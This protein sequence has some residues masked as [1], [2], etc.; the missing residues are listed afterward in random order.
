MKRACLALCALSS[1]VLVIVGCNS[2]KM[3]FDL[4]MAGVDAVASV[5]VR[6][7]A[8]ETVAVAL[9]ETLTRDGLQAEILRSADTIVVTSKTKAGLSFALVLKEQRA[10]DGRV[11]TKVALEWQDTRKDQH[12][13]G[14]IFGEVAQPGAKK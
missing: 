9:Q 3:D 5:G 8:A 11:Q 13:N 2:L 14:L 6:D 10:G 1:V 7:G 4:G 12:I